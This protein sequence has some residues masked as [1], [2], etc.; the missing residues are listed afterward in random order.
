MAPLTVL[1]T[2]PDPT[3]CTVFLVRAETSARLEKLLSALARRSPETVLVVVDDVADAA[4]ARAALR[5]DYRCEVHLVDGRSPGP[6]AA[7]LADEMARTRPMLSAC[8]LEPDAEGGAVV[9]PVHPMEL[10]SRLGPAR[11]VR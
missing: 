1:R 5:W 8:A 9:R 4:V 6:A 7:R 2:H 3:R 10:L 11:P